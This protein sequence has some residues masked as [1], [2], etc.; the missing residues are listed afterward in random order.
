MKTETTHTP[1]PWKIGPEY[2]NKKSR[3]VW[4]G[5]FSTTAKTVARF[6]DSDSSA[7]LIAAAPELLEALKKLLEWGRFPEG[8]P[9]QAVS[10][11]CRAIAKAEGRVA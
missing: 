10:E 6:I 9:M 5:D 11:A 1:G 4:H 8:Y 7:R 2:E 3:S